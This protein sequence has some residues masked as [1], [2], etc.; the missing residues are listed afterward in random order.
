MTVQTKTPIISPSGFLVVDKPSGITSHDAVQKMRRA[1]RLRKIGHLGTLDPIGTGVLVLAVGKATKAVKHFI[2]DD[3]VYLTTLLL[4]VT[5]DTQDVEG[6]VLSEIP[7][8]S[9][10]LAEIEHV[11]QSFQG[12]IQQIPPMV[13]AKKVQGRRLYKLHRKGITVPREPKTVS[14]KKIVLL[15]VNLPEVTFLAE[16]SKGTY[17]RTLCADIG[18]KLGPGGCML[19]LCRLRSGFFYLRDAWSLEV[20]QNM[21]REQIVSLLMPL[22]IAMEKRIRCDTS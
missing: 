19:R 9:L 1:L 15:K 12:E 7:C 21:R 3:K 8:P 18:E 4:G 14:I 2:N 5:T 6:K 17:I 10:P 11:F 13:S 22:G 16:C 20:L